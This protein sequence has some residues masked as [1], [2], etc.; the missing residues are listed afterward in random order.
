MRFS[1]FVIIALWLFMSAGA[2]SNLLVPRNSF[3]I[4]P[5]AGA[6]DLAQ[7]I[8]TEPVVAQRYARHFGRS[9]HEL[10]D[11]FEKNLKLTR[12]ER[13]GIYYVYYSPPDNRVMVERKVLRRGTP[14]FVEKRTGKPVLKANC[15]NPLTPVVSLPQHTI[16]EGSRPSQV[17]VRV[18]PIM[19]ESAPSAV[20]P[21]D[22]ELVEVPVQEAVAADVL[23]AELLAETFPELEPEPLLLAAEPV[24]MPEIP[25][26]PILASAQSP[27]W[28]LLLPAAGF[29]IG[30][31]VNTSS[32]IPE[33][34]SLAGLGV[35][36]L[37]LYPYSR[38]VLR[39]SQKESQRG[40]ASKTLSA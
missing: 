27:W 3:L 26:V 22:V 18:H 35:G 10:A 28:L 17:P 23:P 32:P 11:Y 9:A 15:G 31:G 37:L 25:A 24:S 39:R 21:L 29:A 16:Q 34:T 13:S 12:L 5:V 30:T 20:A 38:R 1:L 33:P 6:R 14:V 7:Q 8:R 40:S 4:R 36:L 19:T 2:E